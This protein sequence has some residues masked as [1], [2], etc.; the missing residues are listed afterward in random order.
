[1]SDRRFGQG[2]NERESS[3][4]VGL[5]GCARGVNSR[6]PA[7][8]APHL[9]DAASEVMATEAARAVARS[10]CRRYRPVA[11]TMAA[12]ASVHQSGTCP[13]TRNP[14]VEWVISEM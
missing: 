6:R 8:Q 12:P 1:M 10:R 14:A 2:C 7:H 4:L 9:R 13:N 3:K 5:A 11:T